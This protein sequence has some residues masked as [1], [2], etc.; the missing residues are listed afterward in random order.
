LLINVQTLKSEDKME[1]IK[2]IG[3]VLA[4]YFDW[5]YHRIDL[6][7]NL[8]SSIIR[9]RS[10]NMQ[11]VAESMEGEAKTSSNYRRIQRFFK[12]QEIDYDVLAKLL[13]SVLPQDEK[14]TI[15]IDRTNWKLGE[16]NIN[17]LVLAA[18]YKGMAIPLFWEFLTTEDDE[19]KGK[20]GNSNTDERKDIL[21]KF[22]EQFGVEKIEVLL[23][24][25]EFIGKEWFKWL[26]EKK[27]P[28]VIRIR[29]DI[30]TDKEFMNTSNIDE[31]FKY[32]EID[33]FYSFGKTKLFDMELYLG[34]K[35]AKKSK[36]PLIVVSNQKIDE[37]LLL[38]YK[39]RWE[40]ETMF[41]AL[42]SK[43]FNLEE[44]K[45]SQKEKVK[46]L[47]GLLAIAFIWSIISGEYRDQ[48]E[49]IGVKKKKRLL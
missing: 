45:I 35:R 21:E 18:A 8:I 25:R 27:I 17:L 44:S 10:V 3:D 33:E 49:P 4:N 34:G 30:N 42:K 22:I 46:K 5:H 16:S 47:M 15:V 9:S 40:I 31:L 2:L 19:E 6:I 28:F 32:I 11:K 1:N 41:G 7:A 29:S 37:E 43:G 36:E 48:H 14:W 26:N 39:K 23:A 13:S 20:R 12:E 24:D 38:K